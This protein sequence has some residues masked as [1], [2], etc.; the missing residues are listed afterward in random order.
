MENILGYT[1]NEAR[2]YFL[3][4]ESYFNFDLPKYFKFQELLNKLSLKP[5]GIYFVK[6]VT[7]IG[8]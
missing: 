3:K 6:V 8:L 5:K 2:N 1:Y 4:E 7:R